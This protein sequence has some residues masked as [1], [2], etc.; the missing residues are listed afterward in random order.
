MMKLKF[1]CWK[2]G[3]CD[4][5]DP[6]VI[7]ILDGN[8]IRLF[9]EDEDDFAMLAENLFTDLDAEDVGKLNK[10]VIQSALLH[11]GVEMGVPPVS[12]YFLIHF[13]GSNS[14]IVYFYACI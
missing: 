14:T 6:I 12:G 11:M 8:T 2:F 7:S 9:L 4:S 1:V 5:D 13:S 3:G 10:S